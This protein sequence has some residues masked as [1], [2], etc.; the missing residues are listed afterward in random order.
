MA[1]SSEAER[2][3]VLP[4]HFDVFQER[5]R[6]RRRDIFDERLFGDPQRPRLVPEQ[7]VVV[8]DAVGDLEMVR[9]VERDALV[10]A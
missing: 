2:Q 9:R 6:A 7:R 1:F 8:A 10:A 3:A 4:K 5:E